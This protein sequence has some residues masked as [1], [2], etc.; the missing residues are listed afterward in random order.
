MGN[1]DELNQKEIGV[2]AG[3]IDSTDIGGYVGMFLFAPMGPFFFDPQSI[4]TALSVPAA[5][6]FGNILGKAFVGY[7]FNCDC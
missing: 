4:P 3:G 6:T 5:A 1:I 2:V 7:F